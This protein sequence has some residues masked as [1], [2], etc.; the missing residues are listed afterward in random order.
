MI[1][2]GCSWVTTLLELCKVS[3]PRKA[4]TATEQ[5]KAINKNKAGAFK[6][7]QIQYHRFVEDCVGR[8][9]R[10]RENL[11]KTHEETYGYEF[12]WENWRL[13]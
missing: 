6:D 3:K 1:I 4:K 9:N 7:M 5:N 11:S 10:I 13:K 12:I 2:Y 8:R